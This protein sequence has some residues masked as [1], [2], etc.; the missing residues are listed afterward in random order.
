MVTSRNASLD[1]L[2]AVAVLLVLFHHHG[3]LNSG[4]FGVDIFFALSG[5]LITTILRRGRDTP[6]Y[7]R[8]FWI[9]RVL[10]IMPPVALVLLLTVALSFP[11]SWLQTVAYLLSL[12]DVLG[13]LHPTFEALRPFWSLAVE[14]HFYLL[15]PFAIR[16]WT[17]S[18]LLMNLLGLIV[19]EPVLRGFSSI[20]S[21]Q[22][23]LTYFLSP[24][25]LD[26]LAAGALLAILLEDARSAARIR[27]WCA[28]MG[29]FAAMIWLA[30][31]LL[32][33]SAFT[34]DNPTIAYN[35]CCYSL[36]AA[37]AVCGV[38]YLLTRP[39]SWAARILGVRPLAWLGLISY[40][41]YLY[42][43]PV[44][45][46]L[47]RLRP[48][49]AYNGLFIDGPITLVLA[50]VSYYLVEKPAMRLGHSIASP[51]PRVEVERVVSPAH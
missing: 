39:G 48:Q 41:F 33:G 19:L 47:L 3:L 34:R 21:H 12:G 22:W 1:G 17:R 46:A 35:A 24:F 18:T 40:G 23:E 8:Q 36:V 2:R 20:Y 5:Y 27:Q 30:L 15:W 45:G 31:R 32:L 38:A 26:G 28:P 25:R 13:Y 7:W 43:S 16:W 29:I 10:R 37:V 4:W 42:Q 9:K 51:K 14:E 44:H 50:V 49:A 6:H 11:L